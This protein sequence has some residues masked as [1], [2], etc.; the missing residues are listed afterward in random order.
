MEHRWDP[1]KKITVNASLHFRQKC[2]GCVIR[3]VSRGGMFI[4]IKGNKLPLGAIVDICFELH[5]KNRAIPYRLKGLVI[6]GT[7]NGIGVITN[8][9]N[10]ELTQRQILTYVA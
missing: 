3:D 4:E 5:K 10:D 2:I 9:V 8:D 6:H 7:N 1:R